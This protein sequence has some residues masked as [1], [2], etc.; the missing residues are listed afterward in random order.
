MDQSMPGQ[1]G[2]ASPQSS[3][4]GCPSAGWASGRGASGVLHTVVAWLNE[5]EDAPDAAP[6]DSV[7]RLVADLGAEVIDERRRS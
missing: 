6:P 7:T 3:R 1:P 2:L 5:L 4:A